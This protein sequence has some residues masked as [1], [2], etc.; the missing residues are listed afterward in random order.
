MNSELRGA[1]GNLLISLL[2]GCA[3]TAAFLTLSSRGAAGAVAGV[4]YVAP[5][6][7]CGGESP[8][9]ASVQDA[10][11]AAAEGDEIRVA[12]GTYAGTGDEV[13]RVTK[14]VRIRGG[15]TTTNWSAPHPEAHLTTLDG[16]GV[17]R[18]VSIV[19]PISPGPTSQGQTCPVIEGFRITGGYAEEGGGVSIVDAAATLR[20]NWIEGN[21]ANVTWGSAYGGGLYLDSSPVVLAGNVVQSNTVGGFDEA[22]GGGLYL[23]ASPAELR[24]N[25]IRNNEALEHGGGLFLLQSDVEFSGDTIQGSKAWGSGGG[26]FLDRSDAELTNVVVADNEG[27]GPGSGLHLVSSS[28]HL[29]HT[30]VARNAGGKGTGLFVGK[31]G[32]TGSA[33]WLTNTILVS[34]TVGVSVEA[35][36]AVTLTGVLW[37]GNTVTNAGGGGAIEVSHAVSGAPRFAAD[38]YHLTAGSAAID[39]G[40]GVA[41][42]TDI[43]REPRFD[44][45]D[46]GVD[47]VWLPGDLKR[48]LLPL[49]TTSS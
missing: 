1:I 5:G 22:R 35:G 43:D 20:G 37:H 12:A 27:F 10:V 44:V 47:E 38:G 8:C 46:L 36:S 15:Y 41:L 32:P 26:L 40:V 30:T 17:R 49:V 23:T 4:H 42:A 48:I 21:A 34:H 11:D 13:L 39:Q 18:V 45:P 7:A 31:E 29:L 6:G 9:Y 24:N 28:P 16:E 33:A 3:M 14:A 2:I 25:V 19:G